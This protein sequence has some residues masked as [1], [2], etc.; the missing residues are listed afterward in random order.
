MLYN[1]HLVIADTFLKNRPNHGQTLMKKPLYSGH[2]YSE[3]LLKR[4]L[5]LSIARIFWTKFTSY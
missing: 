5:F 4:T 3:H 1:G 2:F